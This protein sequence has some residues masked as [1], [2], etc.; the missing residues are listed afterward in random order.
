[1]NKAHTF[2]PSNRIRRW[3]GKKA[4]SIQV[5]HPLH[6]IKLTFPETSTLPSHIATITSLLSQGST[7]LVFLNGF[8]K[9]RLHDILT[10]QI[11]D[12]SISKADILSMFLIFFFFREW[13][14]LLPTSIIKKPSLTFLSPSH[15]SFWL[16]SFVRCYL[17]FLILFFSFYLHDHYWIQVHHLSPGWMNATNS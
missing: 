6:Q 14:Q 13:N 15:S 16:S 7:L 3:E 1:M 5:F 4:L 2:N 8:G 17:Y 9:I 12:A 11:P 10:S